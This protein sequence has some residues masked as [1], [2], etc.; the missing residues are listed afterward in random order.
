MALSLYGVVPLL[1]LIIETS[2]H[3]RQEQEAE[4]LLFKSGEFSL[5]HHIEQARTVWEELVDRFG[6]IKDPEIQQVVA[7]A[8]NLLSL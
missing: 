1:F 5:L 6:D 3:T 7:F 8:R 4:A 2:S